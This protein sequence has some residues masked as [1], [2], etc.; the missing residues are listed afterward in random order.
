MW[1]YGMSWWMWFWM[2]SFWIVIGVIVWSL[3]RWGQRPD[4]R[5]AQDILDERYANG[6]LSKD[7]YEE[8]RRVL[9]NH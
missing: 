7:D 3:I 6:E 1:H 5:S 8:R 9:I 4:R 2:T